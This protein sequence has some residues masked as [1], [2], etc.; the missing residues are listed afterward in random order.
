MKKSTIIGFSEKKYQSNGLINGGVYALNV[1]SFLQKSFPAMFSF[2][3][4]YLETECLKGDI[5]GLVSDAY[6]IDIGVPEDYNRA[7]T[8]LPAQLLIV[9][10]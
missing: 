1:E 10:C 5:L 2:E 3:K 9:N 7:Q 6:F 4:D 8:E